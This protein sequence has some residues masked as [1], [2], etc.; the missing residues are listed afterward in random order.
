MTDREQIAAYVKSRSEVT[1]PELQAMFSKDYATIAEIVKQLVSEK[2]IAF[3]AGLSYTVLKR[4][5]PREEQE[6]QKEEE[7]REE[8]T[9]RNTEGAPPPM[10]LDEMMRQKVI[11][12]R[13]ALEE[14]RAEILRTQRLAD[15]KEQ[16]RRELPRDVCELLDG[17]RDGFWVQKEGEKLYLAC[18]GL[19]FGG[20]DIRFS[21]LN[22]GDGLYL[23]DGGASL[24]ALF[25]DSADD[26]SFNGPVSR[27]AERYGADLQERELRVKVTSPKEGAGCAL[28]L[29]AAMERVAALGGE[30]A[31]DAA[32][33]G[34]PSP[35]PPEKALDEAPKDPP[36]GNISR[37]TDLLIPIGELFDGTP[38]K[39]DIAAFRHILIGGG[40]GS[41]KSSFLH[42]VICGLI[43]KYSPDEV[44]FLLFDRGKR[45]FGRY[46]G[47]PHLFTGKVS[48]EPEEAV[49]DLRLAVAEMERRYI[50]FEKKRNA[51]E[52]VRTYAEYVGTRRAADEALPR[53][54]IIADEIGDFSAN[55]EVRELLQRLSQKSRA[56][57]VHLI[58]AVRSFSEETVSS[59]TAS[60]FPTRIS[61]RTE[62]AS[63]SRAVLQ[64]EGAEKLRLPGE[65]LLKCDL[66]PLPFEHIRAKHLTPDEISAAIA[67]AKEKDRAASP[68]EPASP[69]E[70]QTPLSSD[71]P[72]DPACLEALKV[73]IREG[74]AFIS[75]VQRKCSVGYYHAAKIIEWMEEMG[76]V[77]PFENG[78]RT[79]LITAEEFRKKYGTTE[80]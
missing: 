30:N 12:R 19:R 44:R 21:I 63:E 17:L 32:K 14:R 31:E 76:Y 74:E 3:R 29:F 25:R 56:A 50:L 75:L 43:Q 53:L 7:Q 72:E 33:T 62:L 8:R 13:I 11:E 65:M 60:W 18:K 28:R 26:G 41:G 9:E 58:L 61:F 5:P 46:E 67:A 64:Q 37:N 20:Q 70:A 45:E 42:A 69:P 23:S 52:V 35:V 79:V 24:S 2:V 1:I 36:K 10:T 54:L 38:A 22:L 51:G 73:V 77:S 49:A 47:M 80:G 57:G 59:Q 34:S 68:P 71:M 78:R 39:R 16:E 55:D 6:E 15:R 27:I 66:V 48:S 4:E 40:S